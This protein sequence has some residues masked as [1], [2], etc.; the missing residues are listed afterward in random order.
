V[1]ARLSKATRLTRYGGDSYF[2]CVMAAGQTDIALDAHM[3]PYDI[4][5]LI[6]IIRGAGGVV[7]TWDGGDASLG[8]DVI[9]ASCEKTLEEALAIIRQ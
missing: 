5:P 3:E 2:F 1:L 6:P 9:S 8:G 7:C 4:A